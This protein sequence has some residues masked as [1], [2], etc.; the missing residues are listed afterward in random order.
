MFWLQ[1][2]IP[3]SL[4]FGGFY[5]LYLD[6]F[7]GNLFR[8]YQRSS[9]AKFIEISKRQED[10]TQIRQRLNELGKVHSDSYGEFRYEQTLIVAFVLGQEKGIFAM[11]TIIVGALIVLGVFAV[12]ES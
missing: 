11:I 6:D 4:A 1:L 12:A 3:V 7:G 8:K 9:K 5:Y 10:K 2:L